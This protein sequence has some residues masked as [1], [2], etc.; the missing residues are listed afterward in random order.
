MNKSKAIWCAKDRTKAWQNW[1]MGNQLPDGN[2]SCENPLEKVTAL[3][4][5][6]GVSS[7]PTLFYADGKRMLGAYPAQE[8]EAAL[9]KGSEDKKVV[10]Q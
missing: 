5:K 6:L 7:T 1:V 2:A 9:K 8:I 4:K 3:G 10:N